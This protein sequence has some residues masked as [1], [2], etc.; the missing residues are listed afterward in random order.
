MAKNYFLAL[1]F[2]IYNTARDTSKVTLT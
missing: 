1:C 2:S